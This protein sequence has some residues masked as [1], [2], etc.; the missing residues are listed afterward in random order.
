MTNKRKA[1][2]RTK[3]KRSNR[4]NGHP[5]GTWETPYAIGP[6]F[7]YDPND[8]TGIHSYQ[9]PD[10]E[11]AAPG[12][13]EPRGVPSIIHPALLLTNPAAS[14]IRPTLAARMGE[15]LFHAQTMYGQR[16]LSY[17][18]LGIE[19]TTEP[20]HVTYLSDTL[21]GVIIQLNY[22]A[23]FDLNEAYAQ[24][25]HEVIHLIS[26]T[27]DKPVTILEEGLAEMFAY[28]YMRDTMGVEL[29]LRRSLNYREACDLA[30]LLI[31]E[32][33]G[34]IKRMRKEEPVISKI[35]KELIM[36]HYPFIPPQIAARLARTFIPDHVPNL[37]PEILEI[38]EREG[39]LP[40]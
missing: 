35:S 38:Y 39:Q 37:N 15:M 4:R 18:F 11:W 14:K 31:I 23:M 34:G 5:K 25:A 21:K 7:A 27:P 9:R 10:G 26:P 36:K 12:N 29:P 17:T 22:K 16:D 28:L 1:R 20:P 24:L 3:R 13:D 6:V 30:A 40:T 2:R 32:D 8:P 19:F 33:L